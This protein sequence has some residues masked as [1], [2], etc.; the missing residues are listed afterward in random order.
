MRTVQTY[1]MEKK[2]GDSFY[3]KIEDRIGSFHGWG[4]DYEEFDHGV[5]SFSIAIIELSTGEVITPASDMVKFL[6]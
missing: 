2:E 4:A 3:S 6:D 5:G 1:R